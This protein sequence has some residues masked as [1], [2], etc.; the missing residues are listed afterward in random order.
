MRLKRQTSL[1]G[2]ALADRGR[3]MADWAT[4]CASGA[5]ASGKVT[6]IRGVA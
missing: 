5:P 2:L 3:L 1:N 4:Y 6:P